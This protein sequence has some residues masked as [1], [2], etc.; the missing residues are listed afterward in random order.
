MNIGPFIVDFVCFSR[1][2]IIEAD[3]GQHGD[4]DTPRDT[5]LRSQGFIVLHFWNSDIFGNIEGVGRWGAAPKS[6]SAAR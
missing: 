4:A 6:A 5:W 3:G 2:L 1:K